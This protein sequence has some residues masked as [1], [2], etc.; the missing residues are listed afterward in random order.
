MGLH[1]ALPELTHR[2]IGGV[3]SETTAVLLFEM[4]HMG[5]EISGA[6][7][8][9]DEGQEWGLAVCDALSKDAPH[10]ISKSALQ[11]GS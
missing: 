6:G 10:V 1:E 11:P 4:G 7:Q 2:L 3:V 8:S 5:D 9:V